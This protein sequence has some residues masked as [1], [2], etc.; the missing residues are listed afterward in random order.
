M[1]NHQVQLDESEHFFIFNGMVKK[2]P[3]KVCVWD[4]WNCFIIVI[5]P[6]TIG[7]PSRGKFLPA[8]TKVPML[9]YWMDWFWSE[10]LGI[11]HS[12]IC[13]THYECVYERAHTTVRRKRS[14]T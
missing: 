12:Y 11:D 5:T 14:V 4:E 8:D 2:V 10:M 3:R 9:S 13:C 1:D 6:T 7:A